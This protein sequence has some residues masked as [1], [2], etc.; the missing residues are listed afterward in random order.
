MPRARNKLTVVAIRATES[1][2]LRDGGGLHLDKD[3][4]AG[5]WVWR[6][7]IAGRRRE[8]GLGAWPSVSLA[9]ARR[10]RDRWESVLGTGVDP[11]AERTRQ[12][13]AE[14]Q[15]IEAHDPTFEEVAKEVLEAKKESLRGGGERGRWMSPLA[16]HVMPKLGKRRIVTITQ[17]DLRDVL[18]PIWKKKTATAE[19]AAQRLAIVFRHA[20]LSG[21]DVDPFVVDAAKQRLGPLIRRIQPTEATPWQ[22][23][24]ALYARLSD[25]ALTSHL[26][27]RWMILTVV[28]SDGCRGARL[29]EI[30]DDIWTVPADR[31]KG[32]EGKVGDFRVPLSAEALE[33]VGSCRPHADLFD[34]IMFPGHMGKPISSRATEVALDALKVAGRPHGFRTSFRTWVQDTDAASY[35][36]AETALG[37]AVGGRV[38]RSYARSDLLERRRALMEKWARFVSGSAATVVALPRRA[39]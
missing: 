18:A 24:P 11:I 1:G 29:S 7:S 19:K 31:V 39:E 33:I 38:E 21:L 5:K 13:E 37:H 9:D 14:R 25:S 36:V 10:S 27:L 2:K 35:D 28:R 4:L 23:M 6:Y 16:I 26:C 32:R 22:E 15:A 30:T 3:G 12:M 8:M 17:A 34:G 20:K